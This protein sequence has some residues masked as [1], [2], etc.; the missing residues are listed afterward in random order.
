ML[1]S[2][3]HL[4]TF[5]N[6]SPALQQMGIFC[7]I[8]LGLLQNLFFYLIVY[9]Q[10]RKQS[11]LLRLLQLKR[12][13]VREELFFPISTPQISLPIAFIHACPLF[14]TADVQS[15]T[16]PCFALPS[17]HA[18]GYRWLPSSAALI[19]HPPFAL[20]EIQPLSCST[21]FIGT[22]GKSGI[23]TP[24]LPCTYYLYIIRARAHTPIHVIQPI[25]LW[26]L[27]RHSRRFS[28]LQAVWEHILLHFALQF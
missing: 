9:Q 13:L 10:N 20:T 26:H 23:V 18:K 14:V 22:D 28:W 16:L 27:S 3:Q 21:G 12:C 11:R 6:K 25:S 7:N 4:A 19:Q 8:V 5:R 15:T 17:N 2:Q 24:K 1:F